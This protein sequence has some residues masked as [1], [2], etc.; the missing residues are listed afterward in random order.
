[1]TCRGGCCGFSYI[2]IRFN[3]ANGDGINSNGDGNDGGNIACREHRRKRR[4]EGRQPVIANANR[5][6]SLKDRHD[7]TVLM[8]TK[9]QKR[10]QQ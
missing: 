8:T 9:M 2:L 3:L 5:Q 4:V 1:M 10:Q 6:N 7:F